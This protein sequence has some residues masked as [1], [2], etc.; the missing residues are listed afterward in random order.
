MLHSVATAVAVSFEIHFSLLQSVATTLAVIYSLK[1]SL[2]G[3]SSCCNIFSMLQSLSTA[4]G[5]D[6]EFVDRGG[7]HQNVHGGLRYNLFQTI[8]EMGSRHQIV[9]IHGCTHMYVLSRHWYHL[10]FSK[11]LLQQYVWKGYRI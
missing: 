8:T 6:A 2:G 7:T 11:P 5:A 4:A 9:P 10:L 1:A 3:N